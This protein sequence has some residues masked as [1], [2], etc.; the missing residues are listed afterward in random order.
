M[1]AG[2]GSQYSPD[3]EIGHKT[4]MVS[5]KHTCARMHTQRYSTLYSGRTVL[6]IMV[7]GLTIW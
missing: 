3:Q 7:N 5:L 6:S 1:V 2:F 4:K